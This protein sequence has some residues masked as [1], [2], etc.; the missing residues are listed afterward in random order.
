MHDLVIRGG[1]VVD[2]TGGPSRTADITVDR[3][4]ITGVGPADGEPATRTVD[5]DGL[6]VEVHPCPEKAVSDGAQSLTLAGFREMM[7]SLSPYLR[8]WKESRAVMTEAG[9]GAR[10]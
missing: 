4:V 10:Q 9:A 5:A 6:V 2:G 1:T 8:L 7:G 3:G